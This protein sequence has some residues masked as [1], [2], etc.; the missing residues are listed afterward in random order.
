MTTDKRSCPA[1]Y[2]T[3]DRFSTTVKIGVSSF[4]IYP[5]RTN[6]GENKRARLTGVTPVALLGLY[7]LAHGPA[8]GTETDPTNDPDQWQLNAAG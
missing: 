2:R 3:F 5:C 8:L 1:A 4:F 7:A 6:M